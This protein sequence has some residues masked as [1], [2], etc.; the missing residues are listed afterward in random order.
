VLTRLEADGFKN[1]LDFNVDLGPFTCIAGPNAV[2]K[3]N[4][5]DVIEFLS[6]LADHPFMQA[7]QRLRAHGTRGTD[8][9]TLFWQ[10]EDASG[11][12]ARMRLAAEMIVP[13]QISDD[14]GRLAEATTTFL[15]YEIELEYQPSADS[16]L[17]QPGRIVLLSEQLRHINRREAATHLSWPHS[18]SRFRD[19]VVLGRRSG[20]AYISTEVDNDGNN[21]V[22]VHQDG[23][24]RGQPR[25][26]PA[27]SAPR[28]V[29]STT[30]TSDDPTILAARREMQH[31]RIL[32]LEPAAMRS[33]DLASDPARIQHDGS[34]LAATL[35]RMASVD[36]K[37]TYA[38]ISSDAAALTDI[39]EVGVDFDRQRELLTLE[40]RIGTGPMLPARALSDG[41]L[42]F[43][44]LCIITH[45]Q[46]FGGLI[47]M[48]EPEN[49]I[50]PAKIESMV[51]LVKRLAVD[52]AEPPGSDNPMRQVIV[53]THS[54]NFVAFQDRNDLLVAVPTS[55]KRPGSDWPVTT[56]RL[57]PM[58][59]SWRA[60]NSPMP[61]T[62]DVIVDYLRSPR[63]ARLQL[64][65][66]YAE[67]GTA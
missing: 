66:P 32:A 10:N 42:R 58:V 19:L 60:P 37:T 3:S 50:H 47:C 4:V 13:R 9:R 22:S 64:E 35:Y 48:E 18:K 43:L 51:D 21:V 46:D 8:P 31:W 33:P 41:T 20:T 38:Q 16:G 53:N 27:E 56:M 7:A 63:E 36:P 26:S 15:R 40:A 57:L 65:L 30:T 34:H 54:P 11:K 67:L 12:A 44:A 2:G 17:H 62:L 28:T 6:L 59:K 39:R 52:P 55:V 24:S 14:F 29:I 45:D 5:F 49:G 1:L 23:G 61:V 25:R